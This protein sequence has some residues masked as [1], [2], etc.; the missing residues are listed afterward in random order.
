MGDKYRSM[1]QDIDLL[2]QAIQD[3]VNVD[4][5]KSMSTFEEKSSKKVQM[6]K[7][8]TNKYNLL[9]QAKLNNISEI[10]TIQ[11][12]Q[13]DEIENKLTYLEKL[14]DEFDEF[15][16]ELAIKKSTKSSSA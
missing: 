10:K 16:N 7:D 14:C 4:S 5:A 12:K 13:L 2:I 15:Q 1:N 6:L 9:N 8:L 11:L 3:K